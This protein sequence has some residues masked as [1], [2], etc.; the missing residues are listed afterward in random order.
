LH[1]GTFPK[2]KSICAGLGSEGKNFKKLEELVLDLLALST[3]FCIPFLLKKVGE[4]TVV[5]SQPPTQPNQLAGQ[6]GEGLSTLRLN[7]HPS[8]E[9]GNSMDEQ[10]AGLFGNGQFDIDPILSTDR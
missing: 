10:R 6:I 7:Y 2:L 1:T 8:A 9:R 5:E 4:L 3:R